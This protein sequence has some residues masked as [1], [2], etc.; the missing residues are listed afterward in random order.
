MREE[1]MIGFRS[2]VGAV[3]LSLFGGILQA[4]TITER[5]SAENLGWYSRHSGEYLFGLNS[6][7]AGRYTDGDYLAEYRNFFVFDLSDYSGNTIQSATL[8]VETGGIA[9]VD[10][11]Y[12]VFP[13]TTSV[14]ALIAGVPNPNKIYG[15]LGDE[16][17]WGSYDITAP[18]TVV[19]IVLNSAGIAAISEGHELFAIGGAITSLTPGSSADQYAFGYI[20]GMASPRLV[21]KTI[22]PVPE[23]GAFALLFMGA[24]SL[25]AFSGR[26]QA[27]R[28][29]S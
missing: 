3:L 8:R 27:R 12:E 28:S 16:V 17:S 24:A 26:R 11:T 29:A 9:G 14:A 6:Y 13:V 10:L 20:D 18:E 21:L 15:D 23:P 19:D 22:V 7:F 2:C 25:L 5:F 1:D 4:E